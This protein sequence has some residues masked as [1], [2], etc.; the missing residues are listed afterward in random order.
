MKDIIIR[1]A[2]SSD[3]KAVLGLIRELAHFEKCAEQV[4]V[5]EK[6]LEHDGFGEKPA[7]HC[8]LACR[9]QDVLGFC[10]SWYRYSTWRGRM[11]Y[12]EDLYI[13]EEFRRMGLGKSLLDTAIGIAR[14]E[15]ISFV[16]LQVLTW[17]EPAIRFYRKYNAVFDD[18]WLNVLIS[19]G[20]QRE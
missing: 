7:F 13:R 4:Q 15:G 12:I 10:L 2:E 11:L 9:G 19:S 8:L 16:H 5:S 3:M 1:K 6:L 20:Q 17:N 14:D 18:G